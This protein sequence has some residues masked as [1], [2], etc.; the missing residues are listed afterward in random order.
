MYPRG[1]ASALDDGID[2]A[3]PRGTGR[4]DSLMSQVIRGVALTLVCLALA[5]TGAPSAQP[6][7]SAASGAAPTAAS[8]A[9]TPPRAAATSPPA[10]PAAAVPLNPPRKVRVAHVGFMPQFSTWLALENGYFRELGLDLEMEPLVGT[11]DITVLLGSG[12]LDVGIAQISPGF[13]NAVARGIGIRMVADHGTTYPGKSSATVSMRGDL[14]AEKPWTG[15]QDL[16]GLKVALQE[17]NAQTEYFLDRGLTQA[18]VPRAEV[19]V[20][21]PMSYPDMAAALSNRAVDVAFLQEPWA[22]QLE[23]RGISKIV[24]YYGD[25]EPGGH[26]AGLLF[27]EAFASN[28]A[29][30]RNFLVAYLRGVRATWDAYDGRTDF[31]EVVPVIQ[32]YSTLKDEA[33]IRLLPPSRQNPE[34]YMDPAKLAR[35][36]DYFAERG[37]VPQKA[38]IAQA[39]DPSFAEYAN[40][41]LPP[42]QSVN[43]PRAR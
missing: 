32:K 41:V 12:Q 29:A 24:A 34:G 35:Y 28:T 19:E 17:V 30:A 33:I 40:S 22:T 38:D 15:F 10:S 5:C 39:Y 6:A 43:D 27:S 36:Q 11:S 21:A 37:L 7:P 25:I 1:S 9:P 3:N 2:P 20:V 14:A 13:F 26:V 8:T 31:A 42:Y 4:R 18:G 23:Q 16:R